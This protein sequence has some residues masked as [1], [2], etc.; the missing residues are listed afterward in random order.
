MK[1]ESGDFVMPGDFLGIIE[2]FLPGDGTYD[3]EGNIK[4]NIIG[5]V[6]IENKKISVIAKTDEP[7][8]LKIN[9][10]I[11][12]QVS[13]LRGQ[14][15]L[16]NINNIKDIDRQL[17]LPYLGAIHISQVKKGYLEKL[18]D[19]FRIGDIIEAEV[20]KITG[21]SVDLNTFD[22]ECGVVKAMCTRCRSYMKTTPQENELEC[23]NC[24]KKE[25]REISNN[26][27]N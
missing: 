2:Q 6:S 26:Y 24:G 22:G 15:A 27:V 3:D 11:Y 5:N 23:E 17:A 21:D 19:A 13:D 10:K 12:A 9:D 20:V 1:V 4:S 18:T 8:I 14:R 7:S 16:I 25:R